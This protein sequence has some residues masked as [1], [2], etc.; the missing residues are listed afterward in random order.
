MTTCGKGRK[1]EGQGKSED[2]N[3]KSERNPKTEIRRDRDDAWR[4]VSGLRI[5]DFGF[6]PF[7]E[8]LAAL[9]LSCAGEFCRFND[10]TR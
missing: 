8:P 9:L 4:F 7:I 5:S 6:M 10:V 2:R 1:G 3:P